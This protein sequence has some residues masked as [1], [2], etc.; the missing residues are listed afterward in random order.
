[1][2][3]L[4]VDTSTKRLAVPTVR[5]PL[6]VPVVVLMGLVSVPVVIL[7]ASRLGIRAVPSVP[8]VILSAS[9]LGISAASKPDTLV[10]VRAPTLADPWTSNLYAG[11]DVPMPTLEVA[12]STNN[13][14]V[15]TV[16]SPLKVPEVASRAPTLAL[17]ETAKLFQY[18]FAQRVFCEVNIAP[19]PSS[20]FMRRPPP[21]PPVNI[22][23]GSYVPVP[24]SVSR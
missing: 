10:T 19:H 20:F 11:E 21:F 12:V 23:L 14:F 17:P 4:E 18:P 9:R 6:K 13:L 2:P 16:R 24:Y 15:P 1:M 22:V 7:S 5:S 3:T 8:V